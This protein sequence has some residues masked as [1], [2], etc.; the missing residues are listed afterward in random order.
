MFRKGKRLTVL[1]AAVMAI[2]LLSG[3]GSSNSGGS[4]TGGGADANPL[5]LIEEGKLIIGSDCDYPPFI[6]MEGDEVSGFEVDLMEA[7]AADLNLELVYL[8]PQNFDTLPTAVAAGSIMDLSVSSL[9]INDERLEL[10]NFCLPYFDSNQAVVVKAGSTLRTVEDLNGLVIGAQSG[11]TGEAWAL[12]NLS[13]ETIIKGYNQTSEGLAALRAGE[14]VA[15]VFDEPVATLQTMT[16]YTDCVVLQVIP[17]G[18]QYGFAVSKDNPALEKAINESLQRLF[19]NG[20]YAGLFAKY[21]DY[22][23][24]IK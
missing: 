24:T 20:T 23:P 16:N 13:A 10:V 1:L 6:S 21:F 12:E 19:D 2:G 5:G 17:T 4:N 14:I 15:L 11:T 22:E 18:E 7:I 3:C 9:T 8:P